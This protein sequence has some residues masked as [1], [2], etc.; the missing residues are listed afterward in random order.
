MGEVEKL[1]V[2]RVGEPRE[3]TEHLEYVPVDHVSLGE[4]GNPLT[5]DMRHV[6]LTVGDIGFR[7]QG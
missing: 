1:R 2:K 4:T 6:D 3:I 5:C 7:A